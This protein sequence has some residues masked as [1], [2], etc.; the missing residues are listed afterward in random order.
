MLLLINM[1]MML[2]VGKDGMIIPQAKPQGH[3]P[4]RKAGDDDDDDDNAAAAAN[5]VVVV[6]DDDDEDWVDGQPVKKATK[7]SHKKASPP[8]LPFPPAAEQ[9]SEDVATEASFEEVYVSSDAAL[10][11]VDRLPPMPPASP[12]TPSA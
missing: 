12:S 11:V 1:K 6:D 8:P 5:H 9:A 2:K 3:I 10:A 7:R 4:K